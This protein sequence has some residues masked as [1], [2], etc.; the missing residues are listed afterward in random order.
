MNTTNLI[1]PIILQL[2]GV[3]VVI[4]EVIIPSGGMLAILSIGLFGY[5]IYMVFINAIL[6]KVIPGPLANLKKGLNFVSWTYDDH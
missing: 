1:F 6:A 3:V 4:A 5:S 2:A